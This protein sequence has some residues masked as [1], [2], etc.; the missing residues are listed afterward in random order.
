MTTSMLLAP[1]LLDAANSGDLTQVQFLLLHQGVSPNIRN[2]GGFCPLHLAS[3]LG[4]TAVVAFLVKHADLDVKTVYGKTPLLLACAYGHE[5]VVRILLECGADVNA[6]ENIM[7][8]T[9]LHYACQ[10]GFIHIAHLLVQY[11][12]SCHVENYDGD[13]ALHIASTKGLHTVCYM[14]LDHGAML[15]C[16]NKQGKTPLQVAANTHVAACIRKYYS[17]LNPVPKTCLSPT[18]ALLL[19]NEKEQNG[20]RNVSNDSSQQVLEDEHIDR[21]VQHM[22][23]QQQELMTVLEDQIKQMAV[24]QEKQHEAATVLEDEVQSLLQAMKETKRSVRLTNL[25]L[26]AHTIR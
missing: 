14:L 8:N 5:N 11:H 22:K 12:A 6:V 3:M 17:R 16:R 4:H 1:K 20:S 18:D 9:A 13:T 15:Q 21:I 2:S 24:L 10:Q 25:A 19:I 23:R 26:K 7:G